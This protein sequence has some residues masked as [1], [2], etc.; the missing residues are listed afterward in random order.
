MRSKKACI[1]T[2][3][4]SCGVPRVPTLICGKPSL[5]V[6]RITQEMATI[7]CRNKGRNS[8]PVFS[9]R[10]AITLLATSASL[11][12]SGKFSRR[13]NPETSGMVSISKTRTV[14]MTP[15]LDEQHYCKYGVGLTGLPL[16]RNSKCSFAAVVSVSPISAIF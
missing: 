5:V 8:L 1:R 10:S 4:S 14:A 6:L 3:S 7:F 12:E 9:A 16:T 15:T 2:F 13:R 11:M